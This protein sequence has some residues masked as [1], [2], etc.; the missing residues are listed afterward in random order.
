MATDLSLLAAVKK[1]YSAG[2]AASKA[3]ERIEK[4]IE[5]GKASFEDADQYAE[6][7]ARI[8]VAAY[9]NVLTV[10][11]SS[12]VAD[13]VIRPTIKQLYHDAA[14]ASG[15]IQEVVH[16]KSGFRIKAVMPMLDKDRLDGLIERMLSDE[17]RDG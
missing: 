4:R 15:R 2:K 17:A 3:L 9:D 10:E 1:Q 16:Q 13:Q 14:E 5:D 8:L 7:L 11:V 6:E 12:E